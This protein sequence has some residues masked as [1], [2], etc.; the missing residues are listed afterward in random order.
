MV[1]ADDEMRNERKKFVNSTPWHDRERTVRRAA[2]LL[3]RRK[4]LI[5]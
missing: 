5:L 1:N 3:T 2:A 4:P